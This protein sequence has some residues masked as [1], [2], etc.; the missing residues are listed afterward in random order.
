VPFSG[1]RRRRPSAATAGSTAASEL[2]QLACT[3]FRRPVFPDQRTVIESLPTTGRTIPSGDRPSNALPLSGG[4]PSAAD[5][6]L[7]RLVGRLFNQESEPR[8]TA[9]AVRV[10]RASEVTA[11]L[12][13]L[14]AQK[15]TP[16]SAA[17]D[18]PSPSSCHLSTSE[19]HPKRQVRPTICLR[20][21]QRL[22]R[23]LI[24]RSH[25]P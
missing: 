1:G 19:L 8:A 17:P 25:V 24:E 3:I 14:P 10:F 13:F 9:I 23:Q 12:H 6:P 16:R 21:L 7:Q 20:A 5:H 4:R 18:S 15:V 2:K 11:H 22:V